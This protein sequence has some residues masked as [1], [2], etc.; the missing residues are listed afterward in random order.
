MGMHSP[1]PLSSYGLSDVSS[2]SDI[3]E[4]LTGEVCTVHILSMGLSLSL[5]VVWLFSSSLTI[6]GYW[7][8]VSCSSQVWT[9]V[10]AQNWWYWLYSCA[11][12]NVATFSLGTSGTVLVNSCL[13]TF[14]ERMMSSDSVGSLMFWFLWDWAQFCGLRSLHFLDGTY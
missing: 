8:S 14:C 2:S 11:S 7:M 9:D 10:A 5:T 1:M 6:A 12:L 13:S 4:G 3:S